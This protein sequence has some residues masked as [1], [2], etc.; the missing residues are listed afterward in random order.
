MIGILNLFNL[1]NKLRTMLNNNI[2]YSDY[3]DEL[4]DEDALDGFQGNEPMFD[5][6][7]EVLVQQEKVLFLCLC[8]SL[9]LYHSFSV[10]TT[11]TNSTYC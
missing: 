2:I 10:N 7:D 4:Q 8:H 11:N 6:L 9:T 1:H 3:I 5:Q